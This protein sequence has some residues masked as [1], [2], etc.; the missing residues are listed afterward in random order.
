MNRRD[1]AI[2]KVTQAVEV[3]TGESD[4]LRYDGKW[5]SAMKVLAVAAIAAYEAH[6]R[7]EVTSVEEL[8]QMPT[9][10]IVEDGH[11]QHV[12][13][14]HGWYCV[15]CDEPDLPTEDIARP[16][17]VIHWGGSDA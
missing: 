11:G 12:K 10:S 1:E 2:E 14:T 17:R 16:A 15:E 9:G 13:R 7:P 8:R 6:M 4:V 3:A 5:D